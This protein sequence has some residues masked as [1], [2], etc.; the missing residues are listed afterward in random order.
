MAGRST[1]VHTAFAT[2][3]VTKGPSLFLQR[4]FRQLLIQIVLRPAA[5]LNI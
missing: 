1:A 4:P 5:P 2:P 3:S